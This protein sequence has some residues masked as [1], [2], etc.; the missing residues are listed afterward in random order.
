[1]C[2]SHINVIE[3]VYSVNQMIK[4]ELISLDNNRQV[5]QIHKRES[6]SVGEPMRLETT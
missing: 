3:S 6:I 1:M 4:L 5:R 2:S